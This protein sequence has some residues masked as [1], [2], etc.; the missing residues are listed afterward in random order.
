[1]AQ[2]LTVIPYPIYPPRGGGALRCFHLLRGLVREHDVYTVILQPEDELCQSRDGYQFPDVIEVYGPTQAPPL[3][4]VFEWLPGQLDTA[5]YYRWLRRSWRGPANGILLQTHHL[6]RQVLRE[7]HI[8]AVILEDLSA[9]LAA[10][11]VRRESSQS[12]LIYDALNINHIVFRQE[13]GSEEPGSKKTKLLRRSY[14]SAH[15]HE[16]HLYHAVHAFFACSDEDREILSSLNDE[17]LPGFTVPNG[18]DTVRKRFDSRPGKSQ[19]QEILFCGSLTW[20]PNYEGLRWFYAEIWPHITARWPD[21]R[22]VVIGRGADKVDLHALQADSRIDVIGEVP[23][24][25]PYYHRTG[26]AVVPL[27]SGSGTRLKILEAMSLGNP[28]VSTSIGAQGI[29]AVNGEHFL[30]ADEPE[31][32]ANAVEQLLLDAAMFDRIRS[33]ARAFV[34]QKY[35]WQVIGQK[36]NRAIGSLL[37]LEFDNFNK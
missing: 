5:L 36:M 21:L 30:L 28:V 31:Q 37:T 32:F 13:M 8:D 6:I 26:I 27:R 35:E 15:W 34:E 1:M 33:A 4:T 16:S 12:A 22:L 29:E 14:A 17:R 3:P 9:M 2:I 19:C 18:V 11:L 24:V 25:D 7:N 10:P 23:D 20:S